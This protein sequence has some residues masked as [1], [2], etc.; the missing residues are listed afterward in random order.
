LLAERYVR[1]WVNCVIASM[2]HCN[3]ACVSLLYCVNASMRQCVNASMRQ[4]VNASMRQ[5]VNASMRQCV[6]VSLHH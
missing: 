2:R 4:C 5:C 3:Y 1:H 6:N